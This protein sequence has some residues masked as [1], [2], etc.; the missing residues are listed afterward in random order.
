M[1]WRKATFPLLGVEGDYVFFQASKKEV[2][3]LYW[4]LRKV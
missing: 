4:A 3:F 1:V 2:G